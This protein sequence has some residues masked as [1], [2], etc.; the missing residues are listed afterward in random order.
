MI[1]R[2]ISSIPAR[3][4]IIIAPLLALLALGAWLLDLRAECTD[5]L[6]Q[7]N[8]LMAAIE[9]AARSGQPLELA[10]VTGFDW[11]QARAFENF[12]PEHERRSCP[13]GWDWPQTTRAELIESGLLSI[14][15]FFNQEKIA[16]Y[17]ELRGDRVSMTGI[18]QV[19]T[20]DIARFSVTEPA[21]GEYR[22]ARL[23]T[24]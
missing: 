14:M 16:G 11:E 18:D 23:A 17:I 2:A 24:P 20:P 9:Q 1:R 7:R 3:P 22:L 15:L 10:R 19:L 13:F 8:R 21:T 5:Q 4:A 12:R 6:E